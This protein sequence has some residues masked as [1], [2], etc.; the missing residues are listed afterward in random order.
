MVTSRRCA[1]NG[2]TATDFRFTR[3][4]VRE[5]PRWGNT[6]VQDR[7]WAGSME[8]E[9]VLRPSR[10]AGPGLRLRA[11][12]Q[13]QGQRRRPSCPGSR[14][15]STRRRGLRLRRQL[16]GGRR[17]TLRGVVGG[18]SAPW[19]GG[20][21]GAESSTETEK[22]LDCRSEAADAENARHGTN[23]A[24]PSS[25]VRSCGPRRRGGVMARERRSRRSAANPERPR[26]ALRVDDALP[27]SAAGEELLRSGPSRT[28]RATSASSSRG[29][30]R[31][32]STRP[33]EVTKP[34]PG[35]LPAA[36]VSLPASRTAS[37]SRLARR[38][39]RLT[40]VRATSSG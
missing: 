19:S 40:P 29:A 1:K 27:R 3:R 22:R 11:G 16:R 6:Q 33:Q 36:P 26:G 35:P 37:R 30:T 14:R 34:D 38:R 24:S 10:P 23:G 31:G 7:I 5:P 21:R 13:R 4:E 9:Y 12:V 28:A 25:Y 17:P 18:W 15:S 20:G 39:R 32:A 2:S 8:M